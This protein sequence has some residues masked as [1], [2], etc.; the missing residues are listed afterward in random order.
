MNKRTTP[1]KNRA[2]LV[3]GLAGILVLLAAVLAGCTS[4]PGTYTSTTPGGMMGG[5]GTTTM[6]GGTTTIPGGT[7]TTTSVASV[8]NGRNIFLY[9][10]SSSGSS[11]TYS[12]GPTMMMQGPITCATC[13]GTDG[14]G[15]TFNIMMQ[16]Y[17]APNITWTELSGPDP[18]MQHPPYTVETLKRAITEGLDPSGSPLDY[19]MPHWQ[20][21]QSDLNDL[22]A[23][24]MT[25]Q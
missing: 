13:H 3:I 10:L 22:V 6:P 18:D 20:M 25:L 1:R 17:H 15:R 11:I 21:S 9:A 16:S 2:S 7:I 24:L 8:S 4:S 23:Y 14:H 5:G 19:P 12:E